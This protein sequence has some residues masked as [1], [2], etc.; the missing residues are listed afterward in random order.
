MLRMRN[1]WATYMECLLRATPGFFLMGEGMTDLTESKN[2]KEYSRKY[3]KDRNER[4][5]TIG[6]SPAISYSA[7]IYDED[8]VAQELVAV[9]DRELIGNAAHR[10]IVSVNLWQPVGANTYIAYLKTYSLI[11]DGKGEG[12]D[13]LVY[14]GNFKSTGENIAGTFNTVTKTFNATAATVI[15]FTC[16]AGTTGKTVIGARTPALTSGNSYVYKLD[17]AEI[18]LPNAG[19][20]LDHTWTA[21]NGTDA[22]DAVNG[23]YLAL[24]EISP[25]SACVAVGQATAVVGS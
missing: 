12:T 10:R 9:S 3:V 7:D 6:F 25:L 19:D 24:V 16:T 1:E 14:T 2:P 8:P 17:D 20:I 15:L 4:T 13:A 21:W 18:S 22:V 5:D 11:P 23:D